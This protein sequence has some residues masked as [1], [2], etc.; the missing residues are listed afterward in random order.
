VLKPELILGFLDKGRR[1]TYEQNCSIKAY[2]Y[3]NIIF[4]EKSG[5]KEEIEKL[6]KGVNTSEE[7]YEIL[8]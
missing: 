4:K 8:K 5:L 1:G 3:L 6:W 7:R 2:L